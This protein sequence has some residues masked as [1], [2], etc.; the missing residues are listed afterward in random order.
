LR[1]TCTAIAS[2]LTPLSAVSLDGIDMQVD[3]EDQMEADDM[4]DVSIEIANANEMPQHVASGGPINI[5]YAKGTFQ[6]IILAANVT[7]INVINWP[8]HAKTGRIVLKVTNTGNFNIS[9]TA[10]PAGTAWVGDAP[11]SISQGASKVDMLVLLSGNAG[12]E[13]FGNIIGQDY[14]A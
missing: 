14:V 8:K 12:V 6:H 3:M 11:P 7:A 5:D 4:V 2:T 9:P 1:D 13:I 10:W